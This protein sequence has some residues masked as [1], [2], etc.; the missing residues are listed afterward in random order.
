MFKYEGLGLVSTT[1]LNNKDI[2]GLDKLLSEPLNGLTKPDMTSK[3]VKAVM[4]MAGNNL[5]GVAKLLGYSNYNEI[6]NISE[7]KIVSR[8]IEKMNTI[9]REGTENADTLMAVDLMSVAGGILIVARDNKATSATALN[10]LQTFKPKNISTITQLLKD[11]Y[12]KEAVTSG[13][14]YDFVIDIS[15]LQKAVNEKNSYTTEEKERILSVLIDDRNGKEARNK[16][17][18]LMKLSDIRAVAQS[19]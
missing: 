16:M 11:S 13:A 15:K 17:L 8:C 18:T 14:V 7:D 9:A 2:Q 10:E 3:E 5:D 19:A 6:K 4:A 1:A 12:K